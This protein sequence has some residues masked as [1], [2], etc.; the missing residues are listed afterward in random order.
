MI[1]PSALLQLH[2]QAAEVQLVDRLTLSHAIS[3]GVLP[4]RY[5]GGLFPCSFSAVQPKLVAA[6]MAQDRGIAEES[7]SN[8]ST[9]K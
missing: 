5:S 1:G 7:S 4:R 3:P 9:G 8:F 6:E 2:K